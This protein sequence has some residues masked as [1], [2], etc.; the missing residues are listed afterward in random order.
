M[1][2]AKNFY[3]ERFELMEEIVKVCKRHGELNKENVFSRKNRPTGECKFCK[4]E[5]NK[6]WYYKSNRKQK[7]NPE[8]SKKYRAIPEVRQKRNFRNRNY[9]AEVKDL[10]VKKQILKKKFY[11]NSKDIPDSFIKAYK[12]LILL[13]RTLRKLKNGD[14]QC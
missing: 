8:W 7:Q 5:S 6:K 14:K 11:L 4:R 3:E 13:R 2:R 10:Y 1:E 9:V 12:E